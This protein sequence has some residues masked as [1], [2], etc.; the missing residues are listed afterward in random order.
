MVEFYHVGA[1]E[2]IGPF[3]VVDLKTDVE[4]FDILILDRYQVPIYSGSEVSFEDKATNTIKII[5][6]NTVCTCYSG[7]NFA[8]YFIVD[9]FPLREVN[10]GKGVVV[11]FD[12]V[13]KFPMEIQ[14]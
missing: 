11:P 9:S 5:A 3:W 4:E 6:C 1:M 14:K 13:L 7:D 8:S 12:E 10:N 2:R